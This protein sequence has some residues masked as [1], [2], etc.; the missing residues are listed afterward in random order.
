M[1][2][3]VHVTNSFK[4]FDLCRSFHYWVTEIVGFLNEKKSVLKERLKV[5]LSLL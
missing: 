5:A 3:H 2:L 4:P 1:M